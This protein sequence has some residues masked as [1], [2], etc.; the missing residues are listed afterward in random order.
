MERGLL[1]HLPSDEGQDAFA[2]GIAILG[3]ND[4]EYEAQ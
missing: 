4:C 3:A 2:A 1:P